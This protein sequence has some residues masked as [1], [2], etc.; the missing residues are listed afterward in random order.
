M[1]TST[2]APADPHQHD[3]DDAGEAEALLRPPTGGWPV[4]VTT[5]SPFGRGLVTTRRVPVGAVLEVAPLIVLPRAADTVLGDLGYLFDVGGR[6]CIAAGAVSFVN[7]SYTPNARYDTEAGDTV[8]V[9]RTLTDL[10]KGTEVLVNYHG[11]PDCT[12][13]LWFD[14]AD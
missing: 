4:R 2:A 9:L 12:D 3:L 7:H 11:E 1:A 6:S 14:V 8:L 10:P 13:P 5:T